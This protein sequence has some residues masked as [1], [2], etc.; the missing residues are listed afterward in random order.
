MFQEMFYVKTKNI[1]YCS[2]ELL[3]NYLCSSYTGFLV[4]LSTPKNGDMESLKFIF[5]K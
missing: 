1:V 5:Y 4:I 3:S 2:M